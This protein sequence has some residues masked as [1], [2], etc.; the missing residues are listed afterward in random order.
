[1]IDIEKV[2]QAALAAT[3]GD[4]KAVCSIPEEGFECFWL[5][6]NDAHFGDI[7]GPQS[8]QQLAD[9]TYIATAN[10]SAIFELINRLEVVTKEKDLL[11]DWL[12]GVREDA[13]QI[14]DLL[15]VPILSD[16]ALAIHELQVKLEA[17]EQDAARW[18]DLVSHQKFNNKPQVGY[19]INRTNDRIAAM[20]EMK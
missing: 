7:H 3:P 13:N 12:N 16:A 4:W 15:R 19:A 9:A 18:R 8:G 1:M 5:M 20:K 11:E 14:C 10:P 17:A 6:H 2:K